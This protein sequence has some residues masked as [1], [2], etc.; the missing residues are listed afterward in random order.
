MNTN[1]GKTARLD[2]LKRKTNAHIPLMFCLLMIYL[3]MCIYIYIYICMDIQNKGMV[4]GDDHIVQH[5]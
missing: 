3:F 2:L 1:V 5:R 4:Y